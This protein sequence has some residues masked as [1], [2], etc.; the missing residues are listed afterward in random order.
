MQIEVENQQSSPD[1][2][3]EAQGRCRRRL[4]R[5]ATWSSTG[6]SA[7]GTLWEVPALGSS[8]RVK[9]KKK[10]KK[11]KKNPPPVSVTISVYLSVYLRMS[12]SLLTSPSS[13]SFSHHSYRRSLTSSL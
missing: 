8:A 5:R 12:V 6:D 2:R 4:E 7:S 1:K 13:N 10:K 9:K 11:K 3:S